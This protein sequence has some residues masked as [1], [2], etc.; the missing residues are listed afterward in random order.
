MST[1]AHMTQ[2]GIL[3]ILAHPLLRPL[4][5]IAHWLGWTLLSSSSTLDFFPAVFKHV[6]LNVINKA[7]GKAQQ[8]KCIESL[9]H[10]PL[11]L[12]CLPPL[13]KKPKSCRQSS[14]KRWSSPLLV[15][16]ALFCMIRTTLWKILDCRT[17]NFQKKHC[18]ASSINAAYSQVAFLH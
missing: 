3:G 14:Y 16:D 15:S 13:A 18:P 17:S 10:V 4:L 1:W 12:C 2:A 9:G 5:E 7:V 8:L 6:L 11:N